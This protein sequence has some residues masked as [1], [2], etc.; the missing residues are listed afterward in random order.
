M[1][2]FSLGFLDSFPLLDFVSQNLDHPFASD[3]FQPL[4]EPNQ[5]LD[6]H[7]LQDLGERILAVFALWNFVLAHASAEITLMHNVAQPLSETAL[8]LAC[9][10]AEVRWRNG[11]G[12][13]RSWRTFSCAA[14]LLKSARGSEEFL[15]R[16]SNLVAADGAL[17][18][19]WHK[20]RSF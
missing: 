3:L 6:V 7:H 17:R 10:F 11:F 9:N 15:L 16:F 13:F 14:L 1:L 20:F 2:L 18:F 12:D 5:L 4:P 19:I 8:R